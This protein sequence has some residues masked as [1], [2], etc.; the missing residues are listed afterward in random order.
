[1]IR[2]ILK[3][4]VAAVKVEAEILLDRVR[5]WMAEPSLPPVEPSVPGGWGEQR[6]TKDAP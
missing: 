6:T 2:Q 5:T 1:M 4:A 3:L